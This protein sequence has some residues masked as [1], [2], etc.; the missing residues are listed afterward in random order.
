[1][2]DRVLFGWLAQAALSNV[3]KTPCAV[4]WAPVKS[5]WRVVR[6]R[7]PKS[8]CLDK[9]A[10]DWTVQPWL[11]TAYHRFVNELALEAP[12]WWRKA[13]HSRFTLLFRAAKFQFRNGTVIAQPEVG[14]MKSG[15]YLTLLLNSVGQVLAHI[16]AKLRL[17]EDPY[18]SLP[19]AM[20]DD[21][22]QSPRGIHDLESYVRELEKL[23]C[24]VKGAV[25]RPDVEFA[26]FQMTD[27]RCVP[28]Y[29]KKHLYKLEYATDLPAYL[30]SMQ[31]LYGHDHTMFS[32][33]HNVAAR[34]CPE[35]AIS[36][37]TAMMFMG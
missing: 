27:R 16:A 2:V 34:K 8:I 29:R 7:F 13:V 25:V 12:D 21:T 30:R 36:T 32:F 3:G 33:F 4:G 22:V 19:F 23:G 11:I 17:G 20:G 1:M 14:V 28:A 18:E 24:K 6:H 35:A 10:W 9:S 31:L 15:C 5:G 37:S 26:G